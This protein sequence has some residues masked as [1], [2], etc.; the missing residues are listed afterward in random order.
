MKEG[1]A[2]LLTLGSSPVCLTVLK[3][4]HTGPSVTLKIHFVIL[5]MV[6]LQKMFLGLL[7]PFHIL[8]DFVVFRE[9]LVTAFGDCCMAVC[10]VQ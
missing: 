3:C 8:T 4:F 1:T 7:W 5:N 9:V 2:A 10:F 6:T